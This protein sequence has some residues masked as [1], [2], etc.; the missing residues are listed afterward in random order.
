M[1]KNKRIKTTGD[2]RAVLAK[3]AEDVVSGK[4]EI[5]KAVALQKIARNIT[6]SL[7]S[8]VKIGIFKKE[9]NEKVHEL[10]S[11]PIS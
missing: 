9:S 5:E 8:E 4:M 1:Q 6:E 2:L 11:L 7:Y 3:A 10:G